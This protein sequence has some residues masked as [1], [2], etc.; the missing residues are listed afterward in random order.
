MSDSDEEC[1][2][3]FII[4]ASFSEIFIFLKILNPN[5]RARI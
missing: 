1:G 2:E 3:N 4:K 5:I